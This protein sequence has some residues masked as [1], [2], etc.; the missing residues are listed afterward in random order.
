MRGK[1]PGEESA[2]TAENTFSPGATSETY[3]PVF[4]NAARVPVIVDAP[5]ERPLPPTP[6][7]VAGCNSAAGYSTGFPAA[8]SFPAA[9]TT[10]TP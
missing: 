6:F 1:R 5:T 4:E 3:P 9:A 2:E 10:S 7:D 8:Y